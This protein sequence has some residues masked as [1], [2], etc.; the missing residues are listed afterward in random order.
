MDIKHVSDL[1]DGE[2]DIYTSI[3][4]KQ[5]MRINEPLPG[6]FIAESAKILRRAL[7]A[8]YEPVSVLMDERILDTSERGLIEECGDIPLYAGSEAVLDQLTGYHLTGGVLCAM[9]RKE[10]ASPETVMNGSRIAVL[11]GVTNPT[12][13]GAIFRNAA[14][15]GIDGVLL[16]RSC[17]DPLY[18]RAVRVSMGTVFMIPWTYIDGRGVK[19]PADGMRLLSESGFKTAAMALKED[20][21]SIKDVSAINPEKLAIL[22]GSEGYGLSDETIGLCDYTVMIP[23]SN[24]VDSLNV[25]AASS[26]AFWELADTV[27]T[28][29]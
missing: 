28:A 4:E 1:S 15:L 9:K 7:D 12:N 11:E 19:W 20:S 21:L 16:T 5:L 18:R 25:A 29:C 27:N 23:M 2:L 17:C 10:L 14:A 13:I 3:S 24:G 22:L 26:L 6:I 8:G